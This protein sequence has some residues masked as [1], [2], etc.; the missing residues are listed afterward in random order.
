MRLSNNFDSFL[1]ICKKLLPVQG[2]GFLIELSN[3]E[4]ITLEYKN[5]EFR[6]SW[7]KKER[8]LFID[9]FGLHTKE[10]A[11]LF[12]EKFNEIYKNISKVEPNIPL[13]EPIKIFITVKKLI[14]TEHDARRIYTKL[15]KNTIGSGRIVIYGS[16]IL[17]KVMINFLIGPVVNMKK[18]KI[19]FFTNAEEGMKWLKK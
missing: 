15:A 17:I 5:N 12:I 6:I 8:I 14:K 7:D 10:T 18:M 13:V 9:N 1:I 4:E 2:S 3:M 11:E 19:R 16:N